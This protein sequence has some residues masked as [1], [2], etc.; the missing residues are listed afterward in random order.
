MNGSAKWEDKESSP[1]KDL[2]LFKTSASSTKRWVVVQRRTMRS[3]ILEA[4]DGDGKL[5]NE[6]YFPGYVFKSKSNSAGEIYVI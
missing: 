3:L 4:I 2:L 5:R 1:F 6:I